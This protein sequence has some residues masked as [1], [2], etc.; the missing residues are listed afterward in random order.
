MSAFGLERSQTNGANKYDHAINLV[1]STKPKESPEETPENGSTAASIPRTD[2]GTLLNRQFTKG[3][4]TLRKELARRKYAKYQEGKESEGGTPRDS[5]D[6]SGPDATQDSQPFQDT[7]RNSRMRDKIPFRG[8]KKAPKLRQESDS[9]IDVLYENQRGSFFCGIPLYSSNSLLNLDPSAWQ[10]ANFQDSAVNITNFQLP[11]PSWAW[12]WKTWYVD[13]S[14]D[15]DEEGWEYSFS[16]NKAYAWHGNHPWLFSFVRRRRWL[17]KR[18]KI[19]L[20]HL[21]EKPSKKMGQ[22]HMLNEDYFTI[23]AARRD[24]SRESS[25]DR[26]TTNRSSSINDRHHDSDDEQ[27]MG[28]IAN[29]SALMLALRQARVDREKIAAVKTF[30]SQGGDELFYLADSIAEILDMFVHQTSRRQLQTYLLEVLDEATTTGTRVEGKGKEKSTKSSDPDIEARK[31]KIDNLIRTIHA[32]GIHINDA[33]YWSDIRARVTS[34]ETDPTNETHALDAT[35]PAEVSEAGAHSH[36][37]DDE[38]PVKQEIKGIPHDAHVSKEPRLTFNL[39]D[40]ANDENAPPS[41]TDK[42]KGKA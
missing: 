14:H 24:R 33:D 3:Q 13:M 42:G 39:H 2:S 26:T 27:D 4:G 23:H 16:F 21:G 29:I 40:G 34:S 8:K 38:T 36:S 1:D 32:A 15:V 20:H 35:E 12:D 18:V 31:R 22:A 28:E 6:D 7:E 30:I 41:A 11:D 9:F 37:E 25:A 10:T 19:H 17:R 5:V